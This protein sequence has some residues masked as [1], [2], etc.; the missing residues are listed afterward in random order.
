MLTICG[1]K[2]IAIT[3][4]TG[5]KITINFLDD[6]KDISAFELERKTLLEHI[7]TRINLVKGTVKETTIKKVITSWK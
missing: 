3:I 7:N 2:K 1:A 5:D 4:K 6:G